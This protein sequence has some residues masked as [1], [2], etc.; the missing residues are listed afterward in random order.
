MDF[1]MGVVVGAVFVLVLVWLS[2]RE[3][4]RILWGSASPTSTNCA[5]V[6]T[7]RSAHCWLLSNHPSSR[8]F[9]KTC[10][11][12]CGHYRERLDTPVA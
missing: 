6:V 9:V 11:T 10:T 8:C 4:R 7:D 1:I 12:G 5:R 2:N 3:V